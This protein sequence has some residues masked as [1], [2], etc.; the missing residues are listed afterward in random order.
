M[1]EGRPGGRSLTE[2]QLQRI[3]ASNPEAPEATDD[4]LAQARPFIEAFPVLA[5]AMRR[6]MGS[7]Q[8]LLEI[9]R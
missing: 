8:E 3:I 5:D 6:N 1:N 2:D 9:V 4:Q 7:E